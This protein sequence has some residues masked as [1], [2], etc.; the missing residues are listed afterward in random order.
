M[1]LLIVALQQATVTKVEITPTNAEIQ[2]GQS[3]RLS[4][5]AADR[6]ELEQA[7]SANGYTATMFHNAETTYQYYGLHQLRDDIHIALEAGVSVIHLASEPLRA[8]Q[9]HERLV[10]RKMPPTEARRRTE[11]MR[12]RHAKLWGRTGPYIRG[13]WKTLDVGLAR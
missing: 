9:I 8:D 13:A 2:V 6:V 5:R 11:D 7:L 4:A 10:G 12:T 3:V 1:L